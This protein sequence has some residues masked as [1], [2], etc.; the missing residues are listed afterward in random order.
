MTFFLLGGI[1]SV[2]LS[3]ILIVI[4]LATHK[5]DERSIVPK[6]IMWVGML[7]SVA[8]AAFLTIEYSFPS[9]SHPKKTSV[10]DHFVEYYGDS[11]YSFIK[12]NTEHIVVDEFI[13][14]EHKQ[15]NTLEEES[16]SITIFKTEVIYDVD[17]DLYITIFLNKYEYTKDYSYQNVVSYA[18]C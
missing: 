17:S 6:I 11:Y 7:F 14:V 2:I 5:I 18:L 1:V 13:S 16:Y 8:G 15:L 12:E 9:V 3:V 10:Y 4:F